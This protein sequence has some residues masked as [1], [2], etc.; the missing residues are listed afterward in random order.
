MINLL[1]PLFAVAASVGAQEYPNPSA[2]PA[3]AAEVSDVSGS[4][5]VPTG[6]AKEEPKSPPRP[7]L[8]AE[9]KK[10]EPAPA[11]IPAPAVRIIGADD[12][13]NFAKAAAEDA[14]AAVQEAA[15]EDLAVFV[16]RHPAAAQAPEAIL[17][18]AGL[19]Q[20]KGDWQPATVS[21]LRLLGTLKRIVDQTH[22]LIFPSSSRMAMP[23][24][25]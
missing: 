2:A 17:L 14:D 21:L 19:K 12:E 13:F 16:R 9:E 7:S 5:D 24:M 18:L 15:M 8:L 3:P 22:T 20:K 6:A 1:F 11:P 4:T 25:L 23:T 10:P